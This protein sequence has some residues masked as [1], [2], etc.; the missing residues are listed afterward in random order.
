MNANT[1]NWYKR[2]PGC[3]GAG[4]VRCLSCNQKMGF[5]QLEIDYKIL[6]INNLTVYIEVMILGPSAR[7]KQE[8]ESFWIESLSS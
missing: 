5:L 7:L 6:K 8:A 2:S 4:D 1:A 3:F